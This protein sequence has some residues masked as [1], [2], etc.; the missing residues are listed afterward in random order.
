MGKRYGT[1]SFYHILSA[2][3]LEQEE[4]TLTRGQKAEKALGK[5]E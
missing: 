1:K 4:K 5:L 2:R 3:K